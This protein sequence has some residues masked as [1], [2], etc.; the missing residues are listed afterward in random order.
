MATPFPY[1]VTA[2]QVGTYFVAQYYQV[3]QQQPE[4]VH[5][6]YTDASTILR[7]D[8]STR[9]TAT[10]RPQ[11]H[12]LVMSLSYVGVEVKTAHSL[13]SWS[14]GVLV[15]VSGSVQKKDLNRRKFFQTFF[16]APQEKGFFVLNDIFHFVDDE[17]IYQLPATFLAHQA[18]VAS[19]I[20][21]PVVASNYMLGGA[22]QVREFVAPINVKENGSIHQYDFGEHLQQGCEAENVLEDSSV[23]AST[24][25]LQNTV[26]T[27]QDALAT[28]TEEALGEPQKH[29]YASI[30]RVSKGQSAP[31]ASSIPSLSKTAP[32]AS[33]WNHAPQSVS[34]QSSAIAVENPGVEVAEGEEISAV[35][36]AGEIKSV[37]LRN[38]S[39]TVSPSEIEVEFKN[40]GKLKPDGVAIRNRKDLSVCYAFVEFE[41]ITGVQNAIKAAKVQIAGRPAYIEERRASST[42]TS[43]G[44]SKFLFFQGISSGGSG[45]GRGG[46]Q[47]EAPRGRFGLRTSGRGSGQDGGG[48]DFYRPRGNGY[49]RPTARQDGGHSGFQES[50]NGQSPVD[51]ST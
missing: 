27:I 51:S 47:S 5:Q 43:R 34:Q 23:D 8:G 13:E 44:G 18:N 46:Y 37:Y 1:P 31:P 11:I 6:F 7:I 24:N 40:F 16:L 25:A 14:G 50:R 49:H 17:P 21:E 33:E 15:M 42:G 3:L 19:S 10:A 45:R 28:P 36:D 32:L 30:L 26:G 41:D 48:R 29:T 2:A 20:P 38:L 22:I 9:E 35:E 4:F 39:P 12:A